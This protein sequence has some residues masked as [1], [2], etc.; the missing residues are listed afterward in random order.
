MEIIG[1]TVVVATDR[2]RKLV[3]G[4]EPHQIQSIQIQHGKHIRNW[5]VINDKGWCVFC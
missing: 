5:L 3:V 4:R 2:T 1:E